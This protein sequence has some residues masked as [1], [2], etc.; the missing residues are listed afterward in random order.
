MSAN[1]PYVFHAYEL[2]CFSAR[3]RP[4]LRTRRVWYEEWHA[5]VREIM[6][7]TGLGFV[8]VV[9]TPDDETWQ[10]TSEILA[11]LEVRHPELLKSPPRQRVVRRGFQ[12]VADESE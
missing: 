6:R 1:A 12:L 5:D 11:R 2:S 4:A 8:P 3:V 7:R 9:I 10:D